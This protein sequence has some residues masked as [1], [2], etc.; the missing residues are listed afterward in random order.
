MSKVVVS[1]EAVDIHFVRPFASTPQMARHL[2]PESEGTPGH[3]H[4]LHLAHFQVPLIARPGTPPPEL[5]GVL[6]AKFPAPLP[7]GLI[8][9]DHS[10]FKEDLFDIVIT[11]AKAKVEPDAMADDFSGKA[12]VFVALRGYTFLP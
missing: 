4:R 5:V 8:Y 6:P 2:P 7:D 3:F 11:E 9:D 12:V 10:P 1:G